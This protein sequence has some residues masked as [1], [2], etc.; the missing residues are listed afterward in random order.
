[1]TNE[2][3][4]F[5]RP[6][7]NRFFHG[8]FQ[9]IRTYLAIGLRYDAVAG[10]GPIELLDLSTCGIEQVD[11]LFCDAE[12]LGKC[13]RLPGTF[14]TFL[15]KNRAADERRL[16]AWCSNVA[17]ISPTSSSAFAVF[18]RVLRNNCPTPTTATPINRVPSIK[19]FFSSHHQVEIK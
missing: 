12:L 16:C 3:P 9:R 5:R 18:A 6:Y 7:P 1:M 14:R 10:T 11:P 13:R 2:R 19:I 8:C 4:N 15:E 17:S